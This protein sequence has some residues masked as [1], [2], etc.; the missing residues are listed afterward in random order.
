MGEYQKITHAAFQFVTLFIFYSGFHDIYNWHIFL[1]A[2]QYSDLFD[3]RN[4]IFYT[5]QVVI[6]MQ[7]KK[8]GYLKME[9]TCDLNTLPQIIWPLHLH[10]RV[11]LDT[12][13]WGQVIN[14]WIPKYYCSF[15]GFYIYRFDSGSINLTFLVLM[16]NLFLTDFL[17][18]FTINAADHYCFLY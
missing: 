11:M 18:F 5:I 9:W 14:G 13:V 6:Y 3:S 1:L 10:K 4:K 7:Q 8:C 16:K 17:F 12:T 2:N 15:P